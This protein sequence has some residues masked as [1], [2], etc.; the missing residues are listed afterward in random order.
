MRELPIKKENIQKTKIYLLKCCETI[1]KWVTRVLSYKVDELPTRYLGMPFY[2]R[3]L[4]S[5]YWDTFVQKVQNK[6]I[7]WKVKCLTYARK[8]ILIKIVLQSILVYS[9]MVFKLP[10][11]IY[12]KID[13]ICNR[14][15]WSRDEEKTKNK[16]DHL[17]HYLY[18]KR[19]GRPCSKENEAS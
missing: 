10:I 1:K 16:F 5:R 11:N 8:I 18:G 9:A 17:E 12:D 6:L 19:K 15:L 4:K 7:G 3:R 2:V 13:K 14:F